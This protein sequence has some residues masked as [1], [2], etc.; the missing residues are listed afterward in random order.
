MGPAS[1]K[2]WLRGI[3]RFCSDTLYTYRQLDCT[4]HSAAISYYAILS[5]MPFLIL[6]LSIVGFVLAAMGAEGDSKR[7]FLNALVGPAHHIAPFLRQELLDQLVAIVEVR[8]V[9]G[10]V[11][12]AAVLFSASL[13]FGALETSLDSIF[14][15]QRSRHYVI[16]KLLFIGF[17]GALVLMVLAGHYLVVVV[18]SW[19]SA[20]EQPPLEEVVYSNGAVGMVISFAGTVLVFVSLVKYFCRMSVPLK[21]LLAG[22]ALFWILFELSKQIFIWFL[23]YFAQFNLVYGSLSTL[24]VV[25]VWVYYTSSIFLLSAVAVRTLLDGEYLGIHLKTQFHYYPMGLGEELEGASTEPGEACTTNKSP[26]TP[27]ATR[28]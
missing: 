18:N 2:R 14:L 28:P 20:V 27:E 11:G 21:S 15:V 10:L 12:F 17:I 25:I 19:L 16:S 13:V 22:S 8:T 4:R 6:L 26:E 24:M 1:V 23:E 3:W 9:T 5:F 7:E